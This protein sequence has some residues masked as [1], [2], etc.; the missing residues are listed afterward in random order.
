MHTWAYYVT[1]HRV[2][3][4]R[5]ESNGR[6]IF[7]DTPTLFFWASTPSRL[8]G[9]YERF[10]ETQCLIF[11]DKALPKRWHIPRSLRGVTIQMKNAEIFHTVRI[12]MSHFYWHLY[13]LNIT[14]FCT[15]SIPQ[16]SKNKAT[17]FRKMTP[18]PSSSKTAW[19]FGSDRRD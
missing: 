1:S 12:S 6:S 13:T 19:S 8:V 11:R 14:V 7:M 15:W 3:S 9:R 2:R 16:Y 5:D 18:L 17:A 10:G 4:C